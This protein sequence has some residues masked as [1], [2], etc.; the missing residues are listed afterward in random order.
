MHITEYA[1][2]SQIVYMPHGTVEAS[3]VSSTFEGARED[4]VQPLTWDAMGSGDSHD[5]RMNDNMLASLYRATGP[6]W[7][8]GLTASGMI[9]RIVRAAN[10]TNEG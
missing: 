1:Y 8:S 9:Y 6:G 2:V 4:M 10:L 5:T 7:H 3:Y